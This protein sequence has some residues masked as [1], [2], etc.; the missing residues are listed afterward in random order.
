MK[1]V[2]FRAPPHLLAA[3]KH[4]DVEGIIDFP[5]AIIVK[6]II[7]MSSFSQLFIITWRETRRVSLCRTYPGPTHAPNHAGT[8]VKET[9]S[10]RSDEILTELCSFL[11]DEVNPAPC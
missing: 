7:A 4:Q 10:S 11:L 1:P 3:S 8:G 6:E 9:F 2:P 5:G